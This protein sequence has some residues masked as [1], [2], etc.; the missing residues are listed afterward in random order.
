MSSAGRAHWHCR[1]DCHGLH[2]TFVEPQP[3]GPAMSE[4]KAEVKEK[5][6][7][8]GQ[9][10]KKNLASKAATSSLGKK[11]IMHF[12]GTQGVNLIDALF[13]TTRMIT[14]EKRAK[15][16]QG[17]I[18]RLALKTKL[19]VDE[20]RVT[21]H[22]V[23]HLIDPV[24][25]FLIKL[26]SASQSKDVDEKTMDA[27]MGNFSRIGQHTEQLLQGKMKDKN[28]AKLKDVFQFYG[29]KEFLGPFLRD[30]KLYDEKIKFTQ[31][32]SQMLKPLLD[33]QEKGK[34][35]TC[36][37]PGCTEIAVK[38]FESFSGSS[39]C[40]IHHLEKYNSL[41]KNTPISHFLCGDGKK[42]PK[43][44]ATI[45]ESKEITVDSVNFYT[46]LTN[47]E[48]ADARIKRVFALEVYK[49]YLTKG[50]PSC[51]LGTADVDEKEFKEVDEKIQQIMKG[52]LTIAAAGDLYG[53]MKRTVGKLVQ[54]AY[55]EVF[56][57][58]PAYKEYM[59][60]VYKLPDFMKPPE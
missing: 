5:K 34:R 2:N 20:K 35:P 60:T 18:L 42:Y 39:F 27:L 23:I 3:P 50:A 54:T 48:S 16:L 44:L 1:P 17:R 30:Q 4:S 36:T 41:I 32:L 56:L 26:N 28:L 21:V 9:K 13:V 38:K 40:P 59:E 22:S 24:Q 52:T 45:R 33:Q 8:L 11:A 25:F 43:F 53:S 57:S 58:S 49:K 37:H 31:N 29:S 51:R 47:F 6:P 10:L 15:Q 14:D 55:Q 7:T 12:L 19:L 46:A